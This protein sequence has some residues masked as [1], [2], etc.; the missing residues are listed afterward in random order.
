M[1][2][3]Y[4]TQVARKFKP[5]AG[6]DDSSKRMLRSSAVVGLVLVGLISWALYRGDE[7]EPD[8]ERALYS[9][10]EDCEAEWGAQ[11]EEDKTTPTNTYGS[12]QGVRYFRGPTV[13]RRSYKSSRSVGTQT[14]RRGGFGSTGRFFSMGS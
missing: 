5:P 14:V 4:S 9:N 12:S 2:K 8:L 3:R 1:S 11:C 10:R 6:L 7:D 13:Q